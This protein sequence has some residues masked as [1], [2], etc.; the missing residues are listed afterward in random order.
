MLQEIRKRSNQ[1][2]QTSVKKI[3]MN[4]SGGTTSLSKF[5]YSPCGPR[6]MHV[7]TPIRSSTLQ[8]HANDNLRQPKVVQKILKYNATETYNQANTSE[9][10]SCGNA[11]NRVFHDS[12]NSHGRIPRPTYADNQ[13][14]IEKLID[15]DVLNEFE[16]GC[17]FDEEYQDD[18]PEMDIFMLEKENYTGENKA[19][20]ETYEGTFSKPL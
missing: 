7:P 6:L 11:N 3:K 18:S 16:N 19:S 13:C 9:N 5:K 20:T 14:Q 8:V 17:N 12:T 15:E 4:E 10:K 1:L 2:L